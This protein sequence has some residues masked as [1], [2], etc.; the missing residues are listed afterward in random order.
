ML[1][2]PTDFEDVESGAFFFLIASYTGVECLYQ[3][4][5]HRKLLGDGLVLRVRHV[6]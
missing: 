2:I 1:S 5:L 3:K 6:S 4:S